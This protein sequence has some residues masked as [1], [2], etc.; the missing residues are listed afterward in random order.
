MVYV[1]EDA[2]PSWLGPT[3]SITA[4]GAAI[5]QV[6]M[7][8]KGRTLQLHKLA[9]LLPVSDEILEDGGPA[10]KS[11][12]TNAVSERLLFSATNLL[13]NGDGVGNPL[14]IL[15]SGALIVQEKETSQTADT[16]NFPNVRK[17]WRRLYGPCRSRAVWLA[18]PDAEEQLQG[19]TTPGGSPVLVYPPDSPC[20][21]LLGRPLL[22]S[23]ACAALGEIGDLILA[24]PKSI[25]SAVHETGDSNGIKQ[26]LSLHVWFDQG[27]G[28]FRFT[29]RLAASP[30]WAA[31]I[32]RRTGGST[33]STFVALEAR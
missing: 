9:V 11:Y 29:L 33:A 1:P 10:L 27:I 2:S 25:F 21:Y 3:P 22:V 19:M 24:D 13:L 4:E 16:I 15:K 30:W 8:L 20:G 31:P 23:E 6:K 28:A 12:L 32:T 5:P 26:D 17:M 18:N 14:G 7:A